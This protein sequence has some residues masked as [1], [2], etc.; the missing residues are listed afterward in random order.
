MIK[1]AEIKKHLGLEDKTAFD[2][3]LADREAAAVAFLERETGV[4]FGAVGSRTHRERGSGTVGLWLPVAP[5]LSD[6]VVDADVVVT[7]HEHPGDTGTTI[8]MTASDGFVV[9]GREALRKDGSVWELDHYY[10]FVFNF[11]Y[12]PGAEPEDVRETVLKLVEYAW[13]T[14]GH[15][16]MESE[17]IGGYIF[18]RGDVMDLE[19]VERTIVHYRV[20]V[21][22]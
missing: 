12:A 21:I 18:R 16:G 5:I 20:A 15:A 22:A 13:N 8:A 7:E 1:L 3:Y 6:P 9:W 11:G 17:H 19:G 10:Q 4:P 2:A 14:R